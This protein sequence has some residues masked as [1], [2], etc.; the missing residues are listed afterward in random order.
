MSRKVIVTFFFNF[1]IWLAKARLS[2]T[3]FFAVFLML[4]WK[5]IFNTCF[6]VFVL[7]LFDGLAVAPVTNTVR[8]SRPEFGS[9]LDQDVFFFSWMAALP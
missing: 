5:F 1:T 4:F 7:Y 9:H 6:S 8:I 3:I 2:K